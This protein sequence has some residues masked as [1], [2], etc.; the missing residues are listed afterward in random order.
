ME[1][2]R[3]RL[4]QKTSAL[5]NTWEYII[6]KYSALTNKGIGAVVWTIY[7]ISFIKSNQ[8][9]YIITLKFS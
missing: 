9:T 6:N 7:L 5:P 8:S 4:E 3:G 1:L 2:F